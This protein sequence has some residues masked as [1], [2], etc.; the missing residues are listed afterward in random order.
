[1]QQTVW[2]ESHHRHGRQPLCNIT[3]VGSNKLISRS[4]EGNGGSQ[5][6]RQR[7]EE[8]GEIC[9]QVQIDR[10][11][12]FWCSLHTWVTLANNTVLNIS[13]YTGKRIL[14]CQP[15]RNDKCMRLWTWRTPSCDSYTM[16][17][18]TKSHTVPSK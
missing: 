14:N 17:L 13:K 12:T 3:H 6:E 9:H 2:M 11:N 15:Q 10:K 7:E 5:R 16:C 4:D 8:Q 1:M 18:C